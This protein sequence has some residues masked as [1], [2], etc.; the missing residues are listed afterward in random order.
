[1]QGLMMKFASILFGICLFLPTLLI[2]QQRLGNQL[3]CIPPGHH[4]FYNKY[5]NMSPVIGEQGFTSALSVFYSRHDERI[6]G[7][8]SDIGLNAEPGGFKLLVEYY[9]KNVDKVQA[10]S[11]LRY[12]AVASLKGS[13]SAYTTHQSDSGVIY[14]SPEP[15]ELWFVFFNNNTADT[16][17]I[18]NTVV[19]ECLNID[20]KNASYC[21]IEQFINDS[22]RLTIRFPAI[23]FMHGK[24]IFNYMQRY[25]N[26]E[27]FRTSTQSCKSN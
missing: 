9:P 5:A 26:S 24:L 15:N 4:K 22:I 21:R 7:M 8:I 1:M 25:V 2:A 20:R 16:Q 18:A 10:K 12:D 3:I 6:V 17:N 23:D 27:I 14:R 13:F 11:H 19:A